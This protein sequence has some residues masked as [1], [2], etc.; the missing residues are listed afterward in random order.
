MSESFTIASSGDVER[1]LG[2]A[3]RHLGYVKKSRSKGITISSTSPPPLKL[4]HAIVASIFSAAAVEAGLNLFISIPI[5]HIRDENIRRFYGSLVTEYFRL[6]VPQKLRFVCEFCPQI[7]E[8]KALLERV[9]DLFAYRNWIIHA[10]PRYIEPLGVAD[11]EELPNQISEENL[12]RYPQLSL[13]RVSSDEVEKAFQHY[14]TA[15]DFI[16]KLTVYGQA[17]EKS[18]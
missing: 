18:T 16:G 5:L 10:F 1:L 13:G 14:Q 11:W 6:P 4:D 9:H 8:E 2:I 17:P 12:I 15:L 7:Q 3:N